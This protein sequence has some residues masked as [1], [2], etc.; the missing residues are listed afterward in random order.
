MGRF[1]QRTYHFLERIK[2][3]SKNFPKNL[4]C[5]GFRTAK[6]I[7]IDGLFPPGKQKNILQRLNAL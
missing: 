7:F 3:E 5:F 2:N 4:R 1:V 6:A